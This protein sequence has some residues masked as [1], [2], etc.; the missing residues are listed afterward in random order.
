MA[1]F[2]PLVALYP[3][4]NTF[5][6]V[7]DK[8]DVPGI[9]ASCAEFGL[10]LNG[11]DTIEDGSMTYTVEMY[12]KKDLTLYSITNC[13]L[14]G[15]TDL[16]DYGSFLRSTCTYLMASNAYVDIDILSFMSSTNTYVSRVNT[17]RETVQEIAKLKVW[18]QYILLD[19]GRTRAMGPRQIYEPDSSVS[20]KVYKSS[21]AFLD[22]IPS[23]FE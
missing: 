17:F 18:S 20:L 3:T 5:V 16:G 9:P 13:F 21:K 1:D 15:D 7:N 8:E 11:K 14:H 2:A 4:V 22:K 6:Y 23:E 10:K 12:K 19:D